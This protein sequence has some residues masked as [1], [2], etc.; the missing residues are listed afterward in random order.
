MLPEYRLRFAT[1][2]SS[3][4]PLGDSSKS[5]LANPSLGPTKERYADVAA[6]FK[7]ATVVEQRDAALV[8]LAFVGI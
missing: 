4:D 3:S 6:N 7:F 2:P 1:K 5:L 8:D